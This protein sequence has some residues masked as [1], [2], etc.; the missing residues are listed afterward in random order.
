MYSNR[1]F[2]CAFSQIKVSSRFAVQ[3]AKMS[4]CVQPPLAVTQD[5]FALDS[6]GTFAR[7]SIPFLLLFCVSVT[8]MMYDRSVNRRTAFKMSARF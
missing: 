8:R 6:L 1:I 2:L 5:Q 3:S 4:V 7:L